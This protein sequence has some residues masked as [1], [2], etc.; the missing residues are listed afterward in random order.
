[1]L[2]Y[3]PIQGVIG[4]SAPAQNAGSVENTGFDLNLFHNNNIGKDWSYNIAL[5]VSYVKNEITDMSGTEGPSSNDKIWN[6]EGYPIGSYYGLVADGFFNTEEDLKNC[7]KR[8]GTEKLGDIK[9]KD[10]NGDGR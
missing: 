7:P 9:Y 10:L 1:M 2:L 4:M 8:L 5:N 6:L 3:L